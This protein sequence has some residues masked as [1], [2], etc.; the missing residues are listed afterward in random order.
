MIPPQAAIPY[1]REIIISADLLPRFAE[2]ACLAAKFRHFN[3]RAVWKGS[4]APVCTLFGRHGND[5]HN[6]TSSC[7]CATRVGRNRGVR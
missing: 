7:R 4:Q 6:S 2:L 3:K 1:A 5:S